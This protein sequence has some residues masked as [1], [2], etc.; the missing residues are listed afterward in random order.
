VRRLE[1]LGFVHMMAQQP[2]GTGFA[3]AVKVTS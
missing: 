2:L 1:G 3:S